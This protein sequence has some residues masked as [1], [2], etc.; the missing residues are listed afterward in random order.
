M[1][2]NKTNIIEVTLG[3]PEI[4]EAI[5][6]YVASKLS[7]EL[8]KNASVNFKLVDVGEDDTYGPYVPEYIVGSVKVRMSN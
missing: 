8:D 1:T 7:R 3:Y 6:S 5:K 4:E 2:I